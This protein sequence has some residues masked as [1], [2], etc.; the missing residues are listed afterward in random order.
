MGQGRGPGEWGLVTVC[1]EQGSRNKMRVEHM[2]MWSYST[3][4]IPYFNPSPRHTRTHIHT[5]MHTY[6]YTGSHKVCCV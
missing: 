5:Y 2:I 1:Q 4:C 6:A 3:G